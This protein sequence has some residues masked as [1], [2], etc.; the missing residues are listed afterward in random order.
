MNLRISAKLPIGFVL[1][2]LAAAVV[3]GIVAFVGARG[4]L[5]EEAEAKLSAVKEARLSE[6]NG[7]LDSVR[8]DVSVLAQNDMVID[9]LTAFEA[10]IDELGDKAEG[11]LQDLYIAKNPHEAGKKHHLDKAGDGGKYSEAHGRYHPWLRAL[12]EGRDYYDVFLVT[13]KGRVAYTVFKEPDFATDLANGK[14]KDSDLARV[15]KAVEANF[16]KGSVAFTD[17]APYAPS[18]GVP[19]GFIA[20]PIFDHE[21]KKHGVLVVQMPIG[22]INK[23][24]QNSVGMGETG[25]TYLVGKDY[26]MRSDSRF[27][28]ESTILR[29]KVETEPVKAA[30]GGKSGVLHSKDYRG[31]PVVSAF[32]QLNFQ[33]TTWALLAEIDQEEVDRPVAAMRN[34]MVVAVLIVVAAVGGIGF[35]VAMGLTRPIGAMVGAMNR[36]ANKDLAVEIPARDRKDEIGEMAAAVQVFKEN[37]IR[38]REMEAEQEAAKK[39]AEEEKKSLMRR[40]ADDFQASVGGVVQAVSSAATQLQSSATAMSATA[41]ETSKQATTVAAA[42]EQAS[43]NVQT[44]ASAAEELSSSIREIGRQV[45]QS[46][47]VAGQAVHEVEQANAKVQGLVSAA[48]KIGEVVALITDI[49]DQTNLLALNAT[50]EA[51]RAGEAGKGFAVVAS[52]VKNLAN[53][54]A[55]ATDEIGAQIGQIQSATQEAVGAIGSIG[56]II[57]QVNEIASAI[58]AAVEEQ[59][60]ATQ[61]IARNVEEASHGTREVS[62]NIGG[63]TQAASETGEASSQILGAARELSQQ[64][65]TLRSKVEGFLAQIRG[66]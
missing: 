18:N 3:T 52:E 37:A 16:V 22:K 14:W 44:V 48:Q 61:E 55:R 25:E 23:I 11:A 15:V 63:V 31:I 12:L 51:A 6:L 40:M 29:K 49:A 1:L 54:T 35:F 42:A 8:V 58:A 13:D 34:F 20:S 9:G 57:G 64:S 10:A 26:L 7:Y 17:F 24:L 53:Q 21:G 2:A 45:G 66:A 62:S 59:G 33:G 39:R 41:E 60:A 5:N 30:L 28:K 19:A 65:E 36:L 38:V 32:T 46:T 4:S 27:D 47:Q 56:R 50:I 43:T